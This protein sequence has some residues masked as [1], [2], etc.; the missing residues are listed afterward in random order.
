MEAVMLHDAND[1]QATQ[2]TSDLL[3]RLAEDPNN[4]IAAVLN[5]EEM[6][7][8]GGFP[9]AAFLVVFKPGYY[10][11]DEES[12][13][14]VT[15]IEGSHGGHGFSPEF[16]EMRASFFLAGPGIARHRDLGLID[17]RQ[18]VPTVADIL[19]VSLP[20]TKAMVLDIRPE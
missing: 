16:A 9:D 11:G 12:G 5:H 1:R 17:M 15:P 7:K 4:G 20:S 2:Q 10:A 14:L 3:H 19:K 8:R 18:I 6:K 13:D